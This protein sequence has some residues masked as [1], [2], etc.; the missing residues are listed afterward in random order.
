M[1]ESNSFKTLQLEVC[2]FLKGWNKFSL[3]LFVVSITTV[4]CHESLS[5]KQNLIFC[6]FL[7]GWSHDFSRIIV[8]VQFTIFKELV[9]ELIT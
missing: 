2:Y 6:S 9:H 4:W 8:C 1:E 3:S 5:K 7:C